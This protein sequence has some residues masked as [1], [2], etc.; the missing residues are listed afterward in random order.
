MYHPR[1]KKVQG[2]FVRQHPLYNTWALMKSRCYNESSPS[3]KNYGGRGIKVCNRWLESF[4]NFALDMGLKPNEFFSLDRIDNNKDYAPENCRWATRKEQND[5]KRTYN[6]NKTGCSGITM[7]DNGFQVR[8][9]INGKR[10]YLGVCDTLEEAINLYKSG[11]KKK[12]RESKYGRDEYG[13][14]KAKNI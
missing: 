12:K 7:Y 6:T 9:M 4:E 5:N 13:R 1:G 2:Y 10:T 3:Y 8:K 11:T 14:Y